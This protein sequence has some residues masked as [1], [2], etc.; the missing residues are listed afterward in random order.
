[1]EGLLHVLQFH[2]RP[3]TYATSDLDIQEVKY[4]S[5]ARKLQVTH[6]LDVQ[7]VTFDPETSALLAEAAAGIGLDE[8]LYAP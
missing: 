3:V 8:D 6:G 5:N 1:V 7:A 4:K 2:Q